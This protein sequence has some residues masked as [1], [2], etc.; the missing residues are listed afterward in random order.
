MSHEQLVEPSA[1]LRAELELRVEHIWHELRECGEQVWVG[2]EEFRE[3]L[4]D[5]LVTL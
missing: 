2:N 5:V 3:S 4:N 1:L